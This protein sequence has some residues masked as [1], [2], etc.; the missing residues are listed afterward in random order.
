M[1][2]DLLK[3]TIVYIY[4]QTDRFQ[5]SLNLKSRTDLTYNTQPFFA[6]INGDLLYVFY[7]Y[8]TSFIGL[9]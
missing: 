6:D 5:F 4:E 7:F 2:S 8:L 3:S 9:R 1:N